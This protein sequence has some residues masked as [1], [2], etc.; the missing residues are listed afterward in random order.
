[1]KAQ[2]K[3]AELQV[4]WQKYGACWNLTI[5]TFCALRDFSNYVETN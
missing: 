3:L 2:I 1:M 4:P 5:W